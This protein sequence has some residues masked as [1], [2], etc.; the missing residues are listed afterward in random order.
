MTRNGAIDSDLTM[1]VLDVLRHDIENLESVLRLLNSATSIGWRAFW[2]HDFTVDEVVP[3]L[4]RLLDEGLIRQL[5]EERGVLVLREQAVP[6]V[7]GTE[8]IWFQIT[9]DALQIWERWEPPTEV[10]GR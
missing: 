1:F 6:I 9:D 3:V 4:N 5:A 7:A 2:P 10:H 8:R